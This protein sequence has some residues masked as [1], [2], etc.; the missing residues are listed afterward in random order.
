[1]RVLHWR[2]HGHLEQEI[3]HGL[4]GL[5]S[6]HNE[7]GLDL[8]GATA[9]SGPAA[10]AA[11]THRG[12]EANEHRPSSVQRTA[13]PASPPAVGAPARGGARGRDARTDLLCREAHIE[14]LPPDLIVQAAQPQGLPLRHGQ[15][16]GFVRTR[17]E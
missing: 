2:T 3:N 12:P 6:C 7:G 4:G 8:P 10:R 16:S 1:M 17:Y 9:V 13:C 11:P 14:R 15:V 5:A